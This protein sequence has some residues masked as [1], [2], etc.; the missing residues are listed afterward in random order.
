MGRQGLV[1]KATVAL[2]CRICTPEG[3]DAVLRG[4]GNR[5]ARSARMK[6]SILLFRK[7][8]GLA[9]GERFGLWTPSASILGPSGL[10]QSNR[11][12]TPQD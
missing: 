3:P 1:G 8:I 12:Q 6:T 7:L 5:T 10:S 4:S 9:R 2:Y 11:Y